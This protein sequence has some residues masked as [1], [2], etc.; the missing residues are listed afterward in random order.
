MSELRAQQEA[1]ASLLRRESSVAA[2]P[3]AQAL[4]SGS[5][6]LAPGAQVEIYREQYFLRHVDALRE[7]FG[8]VAHLL[9]DAAFEELARSYLRAHPPRSFSL[10]DLGRAMCGFVAATPPWQADPRLEDLA[11]VDWAFVEA[12][13]APS[14]PALDAAALAAI[15]VDAWPSL[16]I[17]LQPYVTLVALA[18]PAHDY[19]H[20]VRRGE[21]PDPLTP[22]ASFVAVYRG[23]HALHSLELAPAA[24]ALLDRL[25]AGVPL[26]QACEIAAQVTPN[27]RFQTDL[28]S[29]FQ[30]WT[31]LGL[32][33][34]PRPAS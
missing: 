27:G 2:D 25:A 11:R 20:A 10:R 15:P 7:D 9:G 24:H 19:R 23:P 14:L 30:Q 8:A 6:R 21:A 16:C 12:F 26:G 22:R 32:L 3:A 28:G 34:C 4:A 5:A 1:L 17:A 33:A 13:D 31:A 29:W 18:S